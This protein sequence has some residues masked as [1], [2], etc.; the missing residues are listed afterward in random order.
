MVTV[1]LRNGTIVYFVI[2]QALQRSNP[3]SSDS[4][5]VDGV[6]HVVSVFFNYDTSSNVHDGVINLALH[7]D[8]VFWIVKAL[9]QNLLFAN[10]LCFLQ[11]IFNLL[12]IENLCQLR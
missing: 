7:E 3:T 11:S 12:L 8:M 1:Y 4:H 9:F 2:D 10:S 5:L 6:V